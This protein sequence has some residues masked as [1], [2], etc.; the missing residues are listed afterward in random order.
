MAVVEA[1]FN[2]LIHDRSPATRAFLRFFGTLCSIPTVE[3]IACDMDRGTLHYW[4]K[5]NSDS[6]AGQNAMYDAWR[7]LLASDDVQLGA[8]LHV[9]FTD[10]GD[11]VIPSDADVIFV[12]E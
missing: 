2:S 8:E 9:I 10:E 5:L 6:E 7:R 12:R 11:E 1:P 3:R 4:V